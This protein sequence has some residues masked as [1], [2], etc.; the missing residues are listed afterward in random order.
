MSRKQILRLV[1][2][3]SELGLE[4]LRLT[5]GEPT[6]RSDFLQ[7]ASEI[8]QLDAIKHLALTTNGFRLAQRAQSYM[9][10]GINHINI[11]IDSL[12]P[13][14]FF[15]LTGRDL[16]TSVLE[17]VEACLNLK[18][19]SVKVNALLTEKTLEHDLTPFLKWI[20]TRRLT[21]RFIELMPTA[22][23]KKLREKENFTSANG[24]K[25]IMIQSGWKASPRSSLG[26][27]A[28][29][30][31]HPDSLG[32]LGFIAPFDDGFCGSCNRI[33]VNSYGE[34]RLCLW[35]K[36]DL[37]LMPWL[38][39]DSQIGGLKEHIRE[40]LKLKPAKHRLHQGQYSANP[41]FSM[42]GG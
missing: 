20:Q 28:Q 10:S 19:K 1:R 25:E 7:I 4:K 23:N 16:L 17:G 37:N 26:G 34:L 27:P 35:D 36:N 8:S 6:L 12:N 42:I 5:G 22:S 14:R 11:S 9:D 31:E 3:F 18:F 33:R 13:E 29:V 38:E 41:S 21:L 39:D 32:K 30:F 24:L 15:E 2:A 40:L